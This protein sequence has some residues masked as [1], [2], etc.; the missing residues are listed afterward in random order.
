MM[1]KKTI[2]SKDHLDY[3]TFYT[4]VKGNAPIVIPTRH[5]DIIP[6][7]DIKYSSLNKTCSI[8]YIV[9]SFSNV[10]KNRNDNGNIDQVNVLQIQL[11]QLYI[12]FTAKMNNNI[13]NLI[14]NLS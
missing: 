2:T 14:K 5:S 3:H 7:P 4:S 10:L 9:A 13:P 1:R 8:S 11:E 6:I 12:I